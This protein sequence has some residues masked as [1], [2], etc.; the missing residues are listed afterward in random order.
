MLVCIGLSHLLGE[1]PQCFA[2]ELTEAVE[3]RFALVNFDT[4]QQ[5]HTV[6]DEDIGADN[7]HIGP[8]DHV[9][10]LEDRKWCYIRMEG[11]SFGDVPINLE[12]K[13]EGGDSPNS[14]GVVID[15]IRCIKIAKELNEEE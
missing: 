12:L 10:W 5:L 2:E 3:D 6:T 11:L 1:R 13:L 9:P 14:A 15:A 4:T 8:S 7:I